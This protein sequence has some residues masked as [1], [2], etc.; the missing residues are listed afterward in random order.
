MDNNDL[1]P[2][3][4]SK[5]DDNLSIS[6]QSCPESDGG[7]VICL[8]GYI[9]TYNSPFFQEQINK[10]VD[11]GFYNLIFDCTKL[12]YVSSTGIGAFS[13]FLKTVKAQGGEIIIFGLQGTT[14]EVFQLL[15]FS[16][17]FK[18]KATLE[19]SVALLRQGTHTSVS[20]FP[21]EFSCPVCSKRLRA[22]CA[23][24]FRCSECKS[25]LTVDAQGQITVG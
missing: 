25:I 5:K 15:G 21:K 14:S 4:D 12:N 23:G 11:E 20:V 8:T 22:S 3:F 10:V 16:Q 17:L 2:D 6:L 7:I 18:I 1:V 19:E 24:R 13:S 9:D